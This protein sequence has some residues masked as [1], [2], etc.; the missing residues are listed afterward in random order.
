MRSWAVLVLIGLT[1]GWP[2]TGWAAHQLFESP[3]SATV[4]GRVQKAGVSVDAQIL[5]ADETKD[6]FDVDLIRK[7]VQPIVIEIHNRSQATYR[8]RKTDVDAHYLPAAV[9]AKAAYENPMVIGGAIVGQTV[10]ALHQFIF[11]PPKHATFRPIFNRDVQESFVKEEIP[12]AEIGPNGSLSGFLYLRPL[13]PGATFRVT[14]INRQTQQPLIF[15][16]ARG[17]N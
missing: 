7:G 9:A 11:P 1:I 6:I 15:E 13:A 12:D 5:G 16:I 2:A 14:L 8:F 17:P 10:S 4:P 3:R